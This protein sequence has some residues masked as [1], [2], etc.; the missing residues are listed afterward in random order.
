MRP[1][2]LSPLSAPGLGLPAALKGVCVPPAAVITGP[3]ETE[4]G[5]TE[6][7]GVYSAE[8][9]P[10]RCLLSPHTLGTSP[11]PAPSSASAPSLSA[12]P[13]RPFPSQRKAESLLT[14]V[15]TGPCL[16]NGAREG[17]ALA[18][19]PGSD[20]SRSSGGSVRIRWA[21]ERPLPGAGSGPAC[22]TTG[23]GSRGERE[24]TPED[25]PKLRWSLED[26]VSP[27]SSLTCSLPEVTA[28]WHPH[29]EIPSPTGHG[30]SR[31]SGS[32]AVSSHL[33]GL[34]RPQRP[35]CTRPTARL[36]GT[37]AA[38]PASPALSR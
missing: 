27:S 19:P 1:P 13:A 26:A 16:L 9:R 2:R 14:A 25:L 29:P 36:V 10:V 17:E 35:P 8:D 28:P 18:R 7:G 33:P 5:G 11:P 6:E 24:G 32:Q 21:S 3:W 38:F 12:R 23:R 20:S 37:L 22:R 4:V 15:R 30:R 31:A 34:H